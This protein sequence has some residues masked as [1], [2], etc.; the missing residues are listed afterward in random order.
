MN[1]DNLKIEEHYSITTSAGTMTKEQFERYKQRQKEK[2]ENIPTME[3][4]K[5]K[6]CPLINGTYKTCIKTCAWYDL[7][8]VQCRLQ[9]LPADV[10]TVGKDC[11]LSFGSGVKQCNSSCAMAKNNCC[12]LISLLR[13]GAETE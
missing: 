13:K 3:I 9:A 1:F 5:T 7:E 10:E 2:K 4:P 12:T 6:R 8:D 11:P